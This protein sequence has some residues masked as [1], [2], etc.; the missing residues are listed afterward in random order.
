MSVALI[1]RL[2]GGIVAMGSFLV[3][4]W[5]V[6]TR[7]GQGLALI[8]LGLFAGV[9]FGRVPSRGPRDGAD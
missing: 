7:P 4:L 6:P 9:V 8:G 3:G 5:T 1:V 2:V